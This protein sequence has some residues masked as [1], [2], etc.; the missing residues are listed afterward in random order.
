MDFKAI[1]G[2]LLI[3]LFQS[4]SM[5][6]VEDNQSN[7]SEVL[8]QFISDGKEGDMERILHFTNMKWQ[9]VML[10]QTM[11]N[12]EESAYYKSLLTD[13]GFT[14]NVLTLRDINE[15][16]TK[17]IVKDAIY[18]SELLSDTK[19][20]INTFLGKPIQDYPIYITQ[21]SDSLLM[22]KFSREYEKE[23]FEYLEKESLLEDQK[24]KK[25]ISYYNNAV[26]DHENI[27]ILCIHKNI[28][29]QKGFIKR[30]KFEWDEN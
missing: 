13:H 17:K 18:S 1:A 26:K 7:Y 22:S 27:F 2:V 4:C 23:T 3:V 28:E 16:K 25:F 5:S 11:K 8:F 14:F 6:K 20:P 24:K 15:E 21:V 9:G 10:T 29:K 12:K 19:P 30:Y